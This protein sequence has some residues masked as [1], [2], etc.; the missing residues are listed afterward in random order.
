MKHWNKREKEVKMNEKQLI[1][2]F[3]HLDLFVLIASSNYRERIYRKSNISYVTIDKIL[4]FF[5][6]ID[7]LSKSKENRIV[8]YNYT[9]KG[10]KVYLMALKMKEILL[11]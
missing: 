10:Y 5:V 3:K 7:L 1:K 6:S 11:S 9:E 8:K 2:V 4:K